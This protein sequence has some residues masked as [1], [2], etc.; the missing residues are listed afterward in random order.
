[1]TRFTYYT[2]T[3][4]DGFL[5]DDHDSLD[6][7]LSQ[8]IDADGFLNYDEFIADVGAVVMGAST[9]QWVLDHNTKTGDSWA[10]HQPTWVFTHRKLSPVA[11]NVA[12][13]AGKPTDFAEAITEAA[14]DKKVWIVGGGDLAGQFADAGLLH[15]VMVSYAPVTLGSGRPLFTR[16]YNLEL[17]EFGR[18]K[19][20]LCARYDVIDS[21]S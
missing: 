14:G 7:L 6:W 12:I 2:A 20:F 11:D 15:E 21:R 10:Y 1:M 3:T 19:A 16:A 17:R 13:V 4:L 8:P 9:Y 18:N 5:A